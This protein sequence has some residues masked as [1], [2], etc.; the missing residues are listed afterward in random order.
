MVRGVPCGKVQWEMQGLQEGDIGAGD[1]GAGR[2]VARELLLL[3]GEFLLRAICAMGR[4][5]L[6]G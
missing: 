1:P 4:E 5:V 3:R 2:R 6:T